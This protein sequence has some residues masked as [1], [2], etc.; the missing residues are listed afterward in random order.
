MVRW[1]VLLAEYRAADDAA[2]TTGADEGGRAQGALPL[3]AD[4]VGLPGQDAGDVG[5]AGGGREEDAEVADTDVVGEA[6]E[7]ETWGT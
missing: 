7:W 4:I 5:V 6:E 3:A 1:L 2:D